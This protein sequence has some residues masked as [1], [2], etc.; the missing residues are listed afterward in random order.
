[1]RYVTVALLVLMLAG[2]QTAQRGMEIY[3]TI[4]AQREAQRAAEEAEKKAAADKAEADRLAKVEADKQAAMPKTLVPGAPY[5]LYQDGEDWVFTYKG[6]DGLYKPESRLWLLDAGVRSAQVLQAG[7]YTPEGTVVRWL[8]IGGNSGARADGS[9]AA[10]DDP[11]FYHSNRLK[12]RDAKVSRSGNR[13]VATLRDGR[14]LQ[15]VIVDRE[16]RQE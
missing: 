7:E 5:R 16:V 8:R 12:L 3:E 1:M 10:A 4:E 9:Q 14:K 6:G 15:M 2:C 13:L 11:G